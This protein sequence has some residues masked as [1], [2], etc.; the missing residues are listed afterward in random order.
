LNAVLKLLPVLVGMGV[1]FTLR[2]LAVASQSDGEFVF[3]LVFYVFIPALLFTTL[4]T[5]PVS[6]EV[7]V[8]LLAPIFAVGVGYLAGR[9]V[10]RT[11]LFTDTQIPVL[12]VASMVVNAGFPLPFAQAVHGV[13]GVIRI[14]AFDAVNTIFTFT[15]AYRTAARGNPLHEGG[16]VLLN[17]L[18]RSPPLYAIAAGLAVKLT[19]VPVP[20]S[21]DS[22]AR[23]FGSATTVLIS[24]GVGIMFAPVRGELRRASV[25]VATR[26]ATG[27]LVGVAIVL[28]FGLTGVDRS[29]ILLLS[30]TP[31]AFV[32]VTFA[33]LENL[34]V[35]LAAA[36]LSLAMPVST[37]L[38]LLVGLLTT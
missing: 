37:V 26:L 7:G 31:I 2:R 11:S 5:V 27:L 6:S 34:D 16:A 18:V 36:A 22:L 8:F 12:L 24:L 38:S 21:I 15:L 17:R 25:I 13:E 33:S 28:I 29:I 9:L 19:G 35:R 4:S 3:K 14:A 23:A 1:G 32:T 20:E 30:V 10:A